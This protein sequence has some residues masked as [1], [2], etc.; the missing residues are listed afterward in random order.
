MLSRT[1]SRIVA[2]PPD[3]G[4]HTEEVLKEFGYDE[5]E[6]AGLRQADAI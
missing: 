2:P 5:K 1:P 4:Q 6:I 3:I